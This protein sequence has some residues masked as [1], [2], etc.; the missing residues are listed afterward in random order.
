M[1]VRES[2]GNG[3]TKWVFWDEDR[4]VGEVKFSI[5]EKQ[6]SL[7]SILSHEK[8]YGTKMVYF[9][10]GLPRINQIVGDVSEGTDPF[11]LSVGA[12]I[13]DEELFIECSRKM[14]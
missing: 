9:L 7:F 6:L 2:F 8:G 5:Y 10:K 3:L 14:K 1:Q 13:E 11:W 4:E 12:T